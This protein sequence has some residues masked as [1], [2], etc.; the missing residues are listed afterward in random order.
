MPTVQKTKE[1]YTFLIYTHPE[2]TGRKKITLLETFNCFR[3]KKEIKT[4]CLLQ[5]SDYV[6]G[7]S[8]EMSAHSNLKINILIRLASPLY[9]T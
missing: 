6:S 1:T 3:E 5:N 7:Y 8:C 9:F 4:M 2:K